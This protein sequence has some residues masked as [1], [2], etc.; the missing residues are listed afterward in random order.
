VFEDDVKEILIEKGFDPEYGARPL[1]R[2]IQKLI[3]D[4]LAQKI[5]ANQVKNN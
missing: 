5:I 3:L 1:Q 2:V 4:P